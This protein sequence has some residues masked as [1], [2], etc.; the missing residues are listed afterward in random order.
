MTPTFWTT[1]I[2]SVEM[3]NNKLIEISLMLLTIVLGG[4]IIGYYW[5]IESAAAMTKVPMVVMIFALAYI[6]TQIA[7]RYLAVEKKWWEWFYYIA[8]TAMIVPI[9]FCSPENEFIFNLITDLGTLFFVV[10]VLFD[11]RQFLA[12]SQ[13]K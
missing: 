12:N 3:K 9:F 13:K 11:G 4:F 7:R 8:L 2:K 1:F 5:S 10:P 6:L